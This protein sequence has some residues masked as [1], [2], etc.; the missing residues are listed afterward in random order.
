MSQPAQAAQPDPAPGEQRRTQMRRVVLSGLLGSTIEY[1][2]FMLYGTVA[3]LVF[4]KLFFTGLSPLAGTIA[5]FGTFAVG[6]LARPLGGALFGH[7]GDRLGRKTMLV[8]SMAMMGVASTL[9]G[10]LPTHDQVGNLAPTLLVVLRLVQGVAVGGEWGGAALLTAEHAA[11]RRRGL[12]TSYVQMGGPAGTVLSTLVLTLF[13]TLPDDQFL[14]WGW[15]VP[16]LLSAA[17]LAMGLFVRL[18]VTESPLF[19][20]VQ[21]SNAVVRRPVME[22][23]RRPKPLLLACFVVFGATVSQALTGVFAI[24]FATGV[25]YERTDILVGQLL[26]GITAAAAMPLSAALSDRIGRRPVLLGAALALAAV[27]FPAFLMVGTG[28]VPLMMLALGLLAPLP[29]GALLGPVPALFSEMFGTST[30]YTG[31]SMGYQLAAVLGGGLA[32]LAATTLLS[33]SGGHSPT[34]VALYMLLA[35]LVSATAIRLTSETHGHDLDHTTTPEPERPLA[36]H[37]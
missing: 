36:G 32:P 33:A 18:K 26:N 3:S 21:Q 22:I 5:A 19:A 25:G 1:Y 15:R 20:E 11:R 17:L 8:L 16:F 28:S 37:L 2:D 4:D 14:S 30:R 35:C 24:S 27:A 31:V 10:L 9:I 34:L 29:M 13:A 23:L 6:Y 12:L 7:F